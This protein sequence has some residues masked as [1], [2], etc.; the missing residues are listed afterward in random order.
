[1]NKI[2]INLITITLML[3]FLGCATEKEQE[4]LIVNSKT[5]RKK[6]KD[7]RYKKNKLIEPFDVNQDGEADMWKI[8]KEI[9]VSDEIRRVF[10]RREIDLNFDGKLN[11]IKFYSEK[12]NIEKEYLDRDLDGIFD[13]I[14]FYEKNVVK[15]IEIYKSNPLE[16]DNL[17]LRKKI[18]PFKVYNYRRGTLKRVTLDTRKSPKE[19]IFLFYKKNKL[20]QIGIDYDDDLKIDERVKAKAKK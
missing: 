5:V 9:T 14:R 17:T 16:K 2:I 3:T 13:D 11:Y 20:E 15:K 4:K 12:G 18:N 1:M 7:K 19:D 6:T 8:Y 10:L